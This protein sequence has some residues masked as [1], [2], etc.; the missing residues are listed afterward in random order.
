MTTMFKTA[1]TGALLA[2]A[3]MAATKETKYNLNGSD[4]GQIS[5]TCDTGKEQSPIDLKTD[6]DT[7]DKMEI[8][9][10]NYY[11]WSLQND[12]YKDEKA[13]T[14]AFPPGSSL[15]N[16]WAATRIASP[17]IEPPRAALRGVS[18]SRASSK[19]S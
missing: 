18:S 10:Y 5:T 13:H 8:I 17:S 4:W 7:S 3:A 19:A 6:T 11:D 12:D 14:I 1:F 9:G 16:A 15:P 2:A